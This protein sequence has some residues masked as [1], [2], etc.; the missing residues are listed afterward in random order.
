ML[1]LFARLQRGF[2]LLLFFNSTG[3]HLLLYL[4]GVS[5]C[6]M[7][8]V[9]RFPLQHP[10]WGQGWQKLTVLCT[11]TPRDFLWEEQKEWREVAPVQLF[12]ISPRIRRLCS[13]KTQQQVNGVTALGRGQQ[14]C[15][16][17]SARLPGGFQGAGQ[18]W[19]PPPQHHRWSRTAAHT[20][21]LRTHRHRSKHLGGLFHKPSWQP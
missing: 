5:A 14:D 1:L 19:A 3:H 17:L 16:V 7:V 2:L 15:G 4:L 20:C 10:F 9:N 18:G 12:A 11:L 21:V 13:A 6:G 8:R